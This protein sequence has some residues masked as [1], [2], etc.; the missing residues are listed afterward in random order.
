MRYIVRV[1][2]GNDIVNIYNSNNYSSALAVEITA[3][4]I[5]GKD[6]VWICD[7]LEEI[8]VG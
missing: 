3:R 2:K 8:L 6:N 4:E 5:Y 7:C 1:V